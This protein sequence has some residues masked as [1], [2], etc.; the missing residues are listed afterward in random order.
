[1]PNEK[2]IKKSYYVMFVTRM[3]KR[4]I[5]QYAVLHV[6]HGSISYA[7]LFHLTERLMK[8]SMKILIVQSALKSKMQP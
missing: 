1:M 6:T 5:K 4:G 2:K 8:K 3:F 7:L